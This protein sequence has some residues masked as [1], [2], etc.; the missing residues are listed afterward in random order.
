M[1][2]RFCWIWI[3]DEE[4]GKVTEIREYMNTELVRE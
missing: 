2:D 3:F 1:S 4:T